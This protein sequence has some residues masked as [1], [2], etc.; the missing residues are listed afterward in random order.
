MAVG[1]TCGAAHSRNERASW[2]VGCGRHPRPKG[3]FPGLGQSAIQPISN[4]ARRPIRPLN[5]LKLPGPLGLAL[6]PMGVGDSPPFPRLPLLFI[7]G[8]V[9]GSRPSGHPAGGA[10][11]SGAPL[12]PRAGCG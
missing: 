3:A 6:S 9:V 4:P 11:E 5:P 10:D 2:V 1:G 7:W 12:E 8:V